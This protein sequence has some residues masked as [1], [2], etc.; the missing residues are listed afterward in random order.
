MK[1]LPIPFFNPTRMKWLIKL[2]PLS[3]RDRYRVQW[4]RAVGGSPLRYRFSRPELPVRADGR[5]FLHLG[6]G[7]V[8][9]PAFV[10]IDAVPL[11]H[12][13]FV[14]SITDLSIFAAESVDLI[15]AS[16]CLEHIQHGKLAAV[17][18]EWRRVLKPG[19]ILRLSVPDFDLIVAAYEATGRDADW[20]MEPLMGG[21]DY[22]H[23]FHFA[24]F[25]KPNLTRRLMIAGF[26]DVR[27]WKPGT[28]DLTTFDDWSARKM[29]VKG[30]PFDVSLNLEAVK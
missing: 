3:V 11:P 6:C 9:H 26:R 16:H 19:G 28:N 23:N 5:V 20:I 27:E 7:R 29:E 4:K 24:V 8:N 30:Q 15:Y 14:R 25:N 17:L 18:G 1:L 12:I 22:E 10:N 2:F 13:H 21:Q